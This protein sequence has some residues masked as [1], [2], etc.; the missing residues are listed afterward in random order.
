VRGTN[1]WQ[2][3][4]VNQG[5]G[6]DDGEGGKKAQIYFPDDA[7]RF[8]VFLLVGACGGAGVIEDILDI[9]AA[10]FARFGVGDLCG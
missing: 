4:A 3:D 5:E 6:I 2:V 7:S 8:L 9:E 10:V 1:I